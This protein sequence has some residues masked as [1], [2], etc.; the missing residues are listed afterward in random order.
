METEAGPARPHGVAMETTPGLGLRSP[1]ALLAQNPAEPLFEAGAAV[2]TARWDLQKHSLLIVIGDIGTESQL[3]AV[4]AHLE[5]GILSWNIDLSSFDLNQQLRL[6]I[7][8]HLAHF[9][10]EVKAPQSQAKALEHR[11]RE[12]KETVKSPVPRHRPAPLPRPGAALLIKHPPT[13]TPSAADS[14]LKLPA[15]AGAAASMRGF[16]LH[17]RVRTEPK[18]LASGDT[19]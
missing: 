16:L 11:C 13:P 8:R 10:S 19:L 9:S 7:T 2:A 17:P 15:E 14:S 1:G 5:Q 3:R 4:R 12:G 18:G 6:F